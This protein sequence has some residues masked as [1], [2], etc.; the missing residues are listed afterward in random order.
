MALF[1]Y[2]DKVKSDNLPDPHGPL[3]RTVPS[4]SIAAANSEIRAVLESK[5]SGGQDEGTLCQVC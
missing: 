2:F 4:N 1:K 5:P 3:A